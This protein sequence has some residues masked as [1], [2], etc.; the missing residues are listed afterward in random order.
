[1][2]N[3][4]I[5]D[6]VEN[7]IVELFNE[8]VINPLSHFSEKSL[9]VRLA[10]KLLSYKQLSTP[11]PTGIDKKY[12][13]QIK[14]LNIQD[15]YAQNVFSVP[16]LQMEYGLNI[17]SQPFRMDIVILNPKEINT[18]CSWQLQNASKNYLSPQVGIEIGT[19]KSGWRKMSRDHLENDARKMVNGKVAKGYIINIMR[20]TNVCQDNT[21]RYIEKE[22]QLENFRKGMKRVANKYKNIN[23]LGLIHHIAYQKIEVFS[24][25]K[26]WNLVNLRNRAFDRRDIEFN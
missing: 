6:I 5:K 4:S 12:A 13:K 17:K 25:S 18:I 16:P 15:N 3:S 10:K 23:W 26:K 21:Q 11:I 24:K 8:V 14:R 9:Q 20:N 19:E 1:L 2:K 7:S 22:E